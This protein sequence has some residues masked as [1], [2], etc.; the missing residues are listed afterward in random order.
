MFLFNPTSPSKA[1]F[2]ESYNT[3]L[4]RT[5]PCS[6]MKGIPAFCCPLVKVF[7]FCV[8]VFQGCEETILQ[9]LRPVVGTSIDFHAAP[10]CLSVHEELL[11]S[12]NAA[13]RGS[14]ARCTLRMTL[15]RTVTAYPQSRHPT[16]IGCPNP[17][18]PWASEAV[19]CH[20]AGLT[21]AFT[22]QGFCGVLC[23]YGTSTT[24]ANPKASCWSTRTRSIWKG[25]MDATVYCSPSCCGDEFGHQGP[26]SLLSLGRA[27]ESRGRLANIFRAQLD[28][29]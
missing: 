7:W 12:D 3:P 27:G 2:Q 9:G 16:E 18:E 29:Q 24:Q 28:H 10:G 14:L 21:M 13:V 26:W 19:P 15:G 22:Y 8:G 1:V 4:F 6:T 20:P 11:L 5:P 25:W 17:Y 23:A